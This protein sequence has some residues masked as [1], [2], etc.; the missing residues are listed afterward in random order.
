MGRVS[1]WAVRRPVYALVTWLVIVI[2]I[3]VIGTKWGGDYN[4]NFNLPDTESTTAT[5]LL[6]NLEGGGAGTGAG[7]DGQIVWRPDSGKVTDAAPTA[8][9]TG[10]LTEISTQPGVACVQTP[11]GEPLGPQCP[12]QP[13]GQ[14]GGSGQGGSQ[15]GGGSGQQLSEDAQGALAHFGQAGI[16]PDGTV[17]YAT[18]T[19]TGKDFNDVST[20]NL[21]KGLDLVKKQNGQEGLTV[22]ANGI[23]GFVGGEPPS[24]ESIGVTVALVILLFAFGALLGAFLPIF[25]AILSV[26]VSTGFVLPIV[27]RFFDVAVFA[28]ILA[29]MIGLGVGIDYSLF[30][31]NRYREA[32]IHGRQPRDA[33]LESV[34]TSGRAVQFAAATVIIALLGLFIIRITFFNGIA[35]AA[36]ATVFMTMV[37]ALLLLPAVL[38]LLGTWAFVGRMAWITDAEAIPRQRLSG[39]PHVIGRILRYVGW[40]LVWPVTIVGWLWR[41]FVRGG[42]PADPSKPNAFARYGAWLQHRP[43]VTGTVALVIMLVVALPTLALRLGFSDDS[44]TP[45]GSPTRIAYDLTADGFGPG[46]NGPFYIAVQLGKAGDQAAITQLTDAL[47]KDPGVALAVAAPVASDATVVPVTVVPTTAPQDKATTD[48]LYHLREDVIPQATSSTGAKAYVGGFQAITADFT[49]VLTDALPW[50]LLVVIGLGFLALMVLFRSIIVPAMGVLSSLLSLGA[51][52]GITVAVFQW[53]WFSS[54][55]KLEATGPIFPF[56][57]IMVFAILFGLSCDYQVFLV[58]RMHEEW[59]STKDNRKA[60]RRG[61]AGSGRVVAMAAAIM[62][63]VFGAFILANDATVKLFGV[64]LSTAVLFDAFV[65][66]LILIPS[67]MTI[68]GKANW[69]LPDW[70]ERFLPHFAVESEDDIEA[71]A[72]EIV[73]VV[74]P[75]EEEEA[76]PARV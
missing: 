33:A 42:R 3:G 37:G 29:S 73:D 57:P 31:I 62:T 54:I 59:V 53:G 12:Q 39:V 41:R 6:Q 65:V 34:R 44:G 61:L 11:F 56:L 13:A 32:I 76:E 10:L 68:V 75:G 72:A 58:S 30:V 74:E 15:G 26:V 1:Q 14:G 71:G 24:S 64:A 63:S 47:N 49:T 52:L 67:L 18:V 7:L 25:S 43:W 20:S 48:L 38:G 66:R 45:Q 17:G 50:F 36:A 55:V 21:T 5:N 16:S 46:V 70:L 28:P 22:G 9:M 69:W 35:V 19:Y 27:A 23:Y 4:N 51:A 2:A 8:A 40:V 60:V